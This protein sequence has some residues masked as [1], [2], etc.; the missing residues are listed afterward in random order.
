MIYHPFR[1]LGLKAVAVAIALLLWLSVSGEQIVERSLGVPLE[2][3]NPP[4]KLELVD[5]PPQTVSV[6]VR[7][8]S[9]LLSHLSGGDV[10]AVLDLSSARPGRMLMPLTPDGVRGPSGV[11]IVQVSP[12][13]VSLQF[14]RSVTR[15][16]HVVP[17][18][19]GE[20]AAGYAVEG[21]TCEPTS[22]EVVGAATTVRQLDKV[23]TD[24]VSVAG[25]KGPVRQAVT[26]GVTIPG[27]R[28]KTPG[29]AVVTV[30]IRPEP[31]ERTI[32]DVPIRLRNLSPRLV[33]Q[34]APASVTI[35]IRGPREVVE[36]MGSE[37]FAASVDLAG[38]AR[39]RYNLQVHVEPLQGIEILHVEPATVVARVR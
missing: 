35:T 20:P 25:A 15:P 2:L 8:S 6:R 13:T 34:L 22:A 12:S 9:G 14:E 30:N 36:S 27:L 37:A 31:E 38:S 3:Q 4:D 39:G 21:F 5:N 32:R 26:M 19:E 11:E 33:G 7:G 29:K 17:S 1:H 18:I 24:P 10:V 28:L 16:V 23:S